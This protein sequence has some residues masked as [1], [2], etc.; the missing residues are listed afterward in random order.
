MERQ[1]RGEP[2]MKP[3][4]IATGYEEPCRG[5]SEPTPKSPELCTRDLMFEQIVRTYLGPSFC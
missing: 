2:R 3:S 4:G 5:A 1:K